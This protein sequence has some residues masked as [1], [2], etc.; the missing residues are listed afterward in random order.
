M[1]LERSLMVAPAVLLAGLAAAGGGLLATPPQAP[2]DLPRG[3]A[4]P[5]PVD[6]SRW[7]ATLAGGPTVELIGVA[8]GPGDKPEA[9]WTPEGSPLLNPPFDGMNANVGVGPGL[10]PRIFAIRVTDPAT[11]APDLHVAWDVPGSQATGMGM[12]KAK[13]PFAEGVRG[14]A[15]YL[16][17]GLTSATLR[18]GVA[19]GPW[20]VLTRREGGGGIMGVGLLGHGVVFS[21]ARA[22]GERTVLAISEDV[23]DKDVRIV[24]IDRDGVEHAPGSH[25]SASAGSA[26]LHDLEFAVTPD[27]IRSIQVQTRPYEWAEFVGVALDPA[28]APAK[29]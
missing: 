9:W 27:K 11:P 16:P 14:A 26:R 22:I 21:R 20:I 25:S 15:F 28:P 3:V 6:P 13:R 24:A 23:R 5:E 7:K 8:A 29:P 2:A 17:E 19:S 10:R 18:V 4:H 1:F 12:L